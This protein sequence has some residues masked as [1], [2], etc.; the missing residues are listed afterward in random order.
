MQAAPEMRQTALARATFDRI[1]A[2]A[3]REAGLMIPP[4]K[5]AMVQSRVSRR[6]RAIALTDFDAYVDLVEREDGASERRQMISVLTTNVSHFFREIHHFEMLRN[7]ILP[8]LL[9]RAASGGR[10]RIW[11]AGCSSG[12]EPCSIAM[13]ILRLDPSA[14]RRDI[15]ILASDIDPVILKAA[16]EATYGGDAMKGVKP[17][18]RERFFER[19]GDM[20]RARP[21]LR[22]LVVVRELNLLADWPMRGRFDVIF[23]RN[24]VIYFHE[25]TQR[26]LW[27]RFREALA[28]GGTIFVGHSERIPEPEKLGLR[29]LG[30]TAYGLDAP[31]H[32]PSNRR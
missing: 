31:G 5:L 27:P 16:R 24:V 32:Q 14:G 3:A 15:R 7:E 12:Q 2:L 20:F 19:V 9:A 26:K 11:S 30:V 1:A 6:M 10:V 29:G 17:A 23:C 13:E 25:E 8:S 22:E 4:T 21:A 28:P 18:D